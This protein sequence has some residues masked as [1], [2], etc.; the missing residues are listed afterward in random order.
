MRANASERSS[1]RRRGSSRSAPSRPTRRV[2]PKCRRGRRRFK[3]PSRFC[4]N[5]GR[6]TTRRTRQNTLTSPRRSDLCRRRSAIAP[7]YRNARRRAAAP[8][9][10]ADDDARQARA[11]G[12]AR[13]RARGR[14]AAE[15]G[16]ARGGGGPGPPPP[17]RR[18]RRRTS[19][20]INHLRPFFVTISLSNRASP[21][22]STTPP[23]FP[24]RGHRRTVS[25]THL[26]LPTKA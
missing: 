16:A 23:L 13:V 25:Y 12:A 15:A 21:P 9:A 4:S 3:P 6:I 18:R 8:E 11:P 10:D 5:R 1:S 2:S 7:S 17:L 14:A 22:F 26:T 19:T 20:I 24:G